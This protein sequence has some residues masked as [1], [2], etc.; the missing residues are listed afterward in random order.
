MLLGSCWRIAPRRS[1]YFKQPRNH[2]SRGGDGGGGGAGGDVGGEGGAEGKG[3]DEGGHGGMWG[4]VLSW[5]MSQPDLVTLES[6]RQV[7]SRSG[8][9]RP[10]VKSSNN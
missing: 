6:L 7:M 10:A 3:G 2:W 4:S 9:I 5:Q 8:T 1:S